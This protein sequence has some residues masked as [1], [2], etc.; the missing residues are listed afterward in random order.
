M[1]VLTDVLQAPG[2]FSVPFRRNPDLEDALSYFRHIQI[3]WDNT[4][5]AQGPLLTKDPQ[6]GL[7]V[8]SGAL[9]PWWLG[10]D[11]EGLIVDLL[12]Y[13]AANNKLSNGDFSLDDL[14]WNRGEDSG[15]AFASGQATHFT[16]FVGED[17]LNHQDSFEVFAGDPMLFGATAYVSSGDPGY[18]RVRAILSGRFVHP[19]LVT[20]GGFESGATGWTVDSDTAIVADANARSGANVLRLGPIPKSDLLPSGFGTWVLDDDVAIDGSTLVLGPVTKPNLITDATNPAKWEL[21]DLP[22]NTNLAFDGN[23]FGGRTVRE[24][25]LLNRSFEDGFANWT[26]SATGNVGTQTDGGAHGTTDY[27]RFS[28]SGTNTALITQELG[29]SGLQP[30]DEIN[31]TGFCRCPEGAVT[32]GGDDIPLIYALRYT[33]E[34]DD[35]TPTQHTEQ[36]KSIDWREV[37]GSTWH[38]QSHRTNIPDYDPDG[39]LQFRVYVPD[40][41]GFAGWWDID[42]FKIQ[43]TRGNVEAIG[44]KDVSGSEDYFAVE[45]GQSYDG[46]IL[47]ETS[48]VR[49]HGQWSLQVA[50]RNSADTDDTETHSAVEY[51]VSEKSD[52]NIRQRLE[53]SFTPEDTHDQ[54]QVR[55]LWQDVYVGGIWAHLD[56]LKVFRSHGHR[57]F[58]RQANIAVTPEVPYR[59]GVWGRVDTALKEGKVWLRVVYQGVDPCD[60][61]QESSQH[62]FKRQDVDVCADAPDYL[63]VDFTPPEGVTMIDAEIWCEDVKGGSFY[64]DDAEVFRTAGV[65]RTVAQTGKTLIPG[66]TYNFKGYIRPDEALTRGKAWLRAT[67]KQD[68]AIDPYYFR[69]PVIVEGSPIEFRDDAFWTEVSLSV[70]PGTGFDYAD[71]EIVCEDVEGGSF[72]VDDLSMVDGDKGSLIIETKLLPTATSPTSVSGSFTVPQG[73]DTAGYQIAV[74]GDDGTGWIVDNAYFRR[75][76]TPVAATT[77]VSDAIAGTGLSVGTL[78]SAGNIGFDLVFRNFTKRQILDEVSRAGVVQPPREWRVNPD[79]SVDWGTP[80]ELFEDRT[81]ILLSEGDC[82]LIQDPDAQ[83]TLEKFATRYKVLGQERRSINGDPYTVT[84]EATND[85]GSYELYDGSTFSRDQ[86]IEDGGIDHAAYAEAVAQDTADTGAEE[87]ESYVLGL[88]D[89]RTLG[90]F[91]VGDWVYLWHPTEGI[92]DYDNPVPLEGRTIYPK[93]LR[94]LERELTCGS[95]PF[96]CVLRRGPED[97]PDG[98]LDLSE[99]VEWPTMTTATVTVGNPRAEFLL[100]PLGGSAGSQFMKY[101]RAVPSA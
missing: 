30:G 58:A 52:T 22:D 10:V 80:E 63:F 31:I 71:I 74:D 34:D 42:H 20:N 69:E 17:Q 23:R 91:N 39:G 49:R 97:D 66:R 76:C 96:R 5:V 35:F 67:L 19:E 47:V 38:K 101:R 9:M 79:G 55:M 84:G 33:E 3:W 78:H 62:D 64:I 2:A 41:I 40:I 32:A 12:R 81:D 6:T 50:T 25:F 77:V 99:F 7:L 11:N 87:Q 93:K 98:G 65:R 54:A 48:N 37:T 27:V 57:R 72:W 45:P 100:N 89:W 16:A 21:G 60:A 4:L 29:S 85:P 56:T 88:A 86:L 70:S 43:R 94:V 28:A 95:G 75:D 18:L 8:A 53:F 24:Q 68:P 83:R 14:Y 44:Q 36:V 1:P 92:A 15:W 90:R 13:C 61:T 46:R 51:Q 82:W 73:A 59:F 26:P